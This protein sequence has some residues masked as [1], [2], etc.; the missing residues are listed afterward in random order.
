MWLLYV[1]LALI[2][3]FIIAEICIARFF[4][5]YALCPHPF[6]LYE[7][8][9]KYPKE[10]FS[11]Q[12]KRYEQGVKELEGFA[13]EPAQI[14][15]KDGLTLRA[16]YYRSKESNGVCVVFMHGH[17]SNGSIDF[18]TEAAFYLQRGCDCLLT[19]QRA[20]G[21]SDGKYITFG[22]KESEDTALW[23]DFV[24]DKYAPEHIILHGMSLGG[25]T[26]LMAAGEKLPRCVHG[27][28]ADCAFTS[29]YEQYSYLLKHQFKL[30]AWLVLPVTQ[31]FVKAKAHF[32][33]KDKDTREIMKKNKLPVL[34]IHGKSDNYVPTY[35]SEQ[36]YSV[37][38]CDKELLLIDDCK[39]AEAF[40]VNEP[41]C[42]AA[43][44]RLVKKATGVTLHE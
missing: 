1:A 35:M 13:S 16:M 25:A 9:K 27:I 8:Q 28:V 38:V 37:A 42:R 3:L 41:A 11:L 30:P 39:H 24:C 18:S 12:I 23:C 2:V 32:G 20:C 22:I 34:F 19:D 15:S 36:N 43:V 14:T 6:D 40:R 21:K 31:I 26:V 4:F 10:D 44:I 17:N 33:F 5:N 7:S 29:P